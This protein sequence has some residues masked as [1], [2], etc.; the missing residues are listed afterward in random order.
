VQNRGSFSNAYLDSPATTSATTYK[1]Q[2]SN[3]SNSAEVGVQIGAVAQST[4]T[5][6]EISA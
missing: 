5:L 1:T 6:I 4:I 3:F 2:F